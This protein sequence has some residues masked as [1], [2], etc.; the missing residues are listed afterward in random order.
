MI[1]DTRP[2]QLVDQAREAATLIGI[3]A[4]YHRNALAPFLARIVSYLCRA[5]RDVPGAHTECLNSIAL[6][7]KHVSPP[8]HDTAFTVYFKHLLDLL[9]EQV[10]LGNNNGT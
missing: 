7:S 10:S 9:A 1:L 3:A 8:P 2:E 5:I 6:V 4:S